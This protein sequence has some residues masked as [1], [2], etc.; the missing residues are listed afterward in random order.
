MLLSVIIVSWNVKEK[1]RENL[2]ALLKSKT[3]FRFEIIVVDN[4]S[5]D[6]SAE[7]VEKEFKGVSIIK[8][9]ANLGFAKANNLALK[10]I[11]SKYALLLN[12]DMLVNSDTIQKMIEWMEKNKQAIV[13]SC[14]LKDE[15]GDIVKH[16]RRFPGIL[17]QLAIA[18]KLPHI[19]PNI[20][21]KY[22][23]TDFNYS[24]SAQVDSVR[25]AFFMINMTEARELKLFRNSTLPFLDE[26]YFIWFEEVDFCKQVKKGGGEV[27]YTPVAECTDYVGASFNQVARA[28]K[29]KYIADSGVK[30][31][32]KWHPGWQWAI[33]KLAW[34]FGKIIV[35][36]SDKI[37]IMS[38]AKT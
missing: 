26:R 20:L 3:G 25:G 17:D 31:F 38:R 6:G 15:K 11:E 28:T 12:P 16:V 32:K 8:N 29:Q 34:F 23:N 2:K 27:W 24:N 14:K 21:N 9:E 36:I 10:Q 5:E 19:Y 7:M 35:N 13:S 4:N 22:L 37:G 30:Y 18:L 1:L 33:L